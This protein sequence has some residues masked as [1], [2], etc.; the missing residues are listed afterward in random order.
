MNLVHCTQSTILMDE[1]M[2]LLSRL[3]RIFLFMLHLKMLNQ[4]SFSREPRQLEEEPAESKLI[5]GRRPDRRPNLP[6]EIEWQD[7]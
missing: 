4:H 2:S 5:E 1:G 7:R 6:T 3:S